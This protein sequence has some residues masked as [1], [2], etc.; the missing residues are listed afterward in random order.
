MLT[1]RQ[2]MNKSK[3]LTSRSDFLEVRRSPK[4][5]AT[6]KTC[7]FFRYQLPIVVIIVNNNG[8]YG[9]LD[10]AL[11]EDIRED[12]PSQN[13]PPTALLPSVKYEKFADMLGMKN[14]FLCRSVDDI[15]VAFSKALANRTEPS[16][17]NIFINPMAQRKAQ[18]HEWLT[19]SKI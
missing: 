6:Y 17:L 8:I 7:L 13:V 15:R 19:R 9:G 5:F 4:R 3:T 2:K 11:F 18:A 12:Q 10:E 16:L 1:N 14:G